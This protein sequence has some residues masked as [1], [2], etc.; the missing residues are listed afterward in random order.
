MKTLPILVLWFVACTVGLVCCTGCAAIH[1]YPPETIRFHH[2]RYSPLY[3]A[4][5][6]HP[7]QPGALTVTRRT[8]AQVTEFYR[9]GG[10]AQR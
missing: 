6:K 8:D 2:Y 5:K 10:Y 9:R 7:Y 1:G 4:A 3:W